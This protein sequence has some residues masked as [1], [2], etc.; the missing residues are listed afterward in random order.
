MSTLVI[1]GNLI[2]D[3]GL[4]T[5][6]DALKQNNSLKYLDVGRCGMTD[7]GV[8]SLADALHT[9]NTLEM[10]YIHDNA[11]ITNNGLTDL[12]EPLS[13]N[14]GL[15]KLV[16]P[17]YLMPSMDEVEKTINESRK[18]SGL[19]AIELQGKYYEKCDCFHWKKK[20]KGVLSQ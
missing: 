18:R 1:S 11:A 8:A 6:F 7:T 17:L 9:N 16:L 14:S 4:Q 12:I 19:A 10:L 3:K 20:W 13:R 5:I 2:G 15:V